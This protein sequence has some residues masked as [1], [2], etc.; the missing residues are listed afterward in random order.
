MEY[1]QIGE[2]ADKIGKHINTVS[3]WFKQ[4]EEKRIHSINRNEH[5]EK[6]YDSLDLE[7]ALH[8]KNKRDEKWTLDAIFNELP[9][10]FELR[11]F[12][13]LEDSK[14]LESTS[15]L[16]INLLRSELEKV[17]HEIAATQ[18]KEMQSQYQELLKRLPEPKD[19]EKERLDRFNE[20]ITRRRIEAHLEKE[21]LNMWATK[22]D[23][24]RLKRVGLFRKEE[25]RDKRERFVKEYINQHFENHLKR[26]FG[27]D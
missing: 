24:E 3:N 27:L 2:F 6:V 25:D 23:E 9:Q 26:E 13:K 18:I 7:I 14:E 16:Q 21:A 12:P 4:L 5:G 22:P 17:V 10:Y 19:P 11:P 20:I 15:P 1:W 8:I